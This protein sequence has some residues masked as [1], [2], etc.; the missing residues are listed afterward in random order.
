MI[1]LATKYSYDIYHRYI[2]SFGVSIDYKYYLSI[3]GVILRLIVVNTNRFVIDYQDIISATV[4]SVNSKFVR[5]Y[6]CNNI[7]KIIRVG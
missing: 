7:N 6:I 2:L 3:N 1:L 5:S 4:F